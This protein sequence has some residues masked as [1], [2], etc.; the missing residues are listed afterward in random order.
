MAWRKDRARQLEMWER[1]MFQSA[2]I[3]KLLQEARGLLRLAETGNKAAFPLLEAILLECLLRQERATAL[4][5]EIWNER[6][7]EARRDDGQS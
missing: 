3:R 1:K 6:L 4:D 2:P 7:G 5:S